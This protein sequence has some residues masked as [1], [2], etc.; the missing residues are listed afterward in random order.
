[1]RNVDTNY[2]GLDWKA[3]FEARLKNH[4]RGSATELGI[5]L[6]AHIA[7]VL[8]SSLL[9]M[10]HIKHLRYHGESALIVSLEALINSGVASRKNEE[11]NLWNGLGLV[12]SLLSD[13]LDCLLEVAIAPTRNVNSRIL[14]GNLSTVGDTGGSRN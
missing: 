11:K 3:R 10:R 8:W 4:L 1:M 9:D 7:A 6:H 2:H 13:V 12:S 5:E 14:V